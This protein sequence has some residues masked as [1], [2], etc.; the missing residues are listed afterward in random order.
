VKCSSVFFLTLVLCSVAPAHSQENRSLVLSQTISLPNVQGGFNHMSVDVEHMRLFVAAPTNNTLEIVDLKTG[1]PWRTLEGGKP[2]AVRYAPEFNQLYVPRGQS[3]DIYDGKTL[4]PIASIDLGSNLDELQYNASAKRLYV[5]CMAPDKTGIAVIAI[6]EGKLLGKIPLPA[7]LQGVAVEQKGSRIFANI[8]GV[9]QIALMDGE[10]GTLLN[11]WL[12]EDVEG[13][14]PLG[15]DEAHH[16]LFVGTRHPAQLLV[17]DTTTGKPTAKVDISSDADDLFYDPVNKRI[18][19]S[20]GEGFIDVIEQ[21]DADHYKLSTRIPTV[22]GA[23]TST[24]S[25]KLNAFYLGVPRR[26]G[27]PAEL[28]IFKVEK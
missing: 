7:K 5:A 10:Q 2:A 28:R 19:V 26:G 15:L 13:N 1:K 25:G 8:P 11:T 16:R 4:D 27:Q 3:L 21:R 9:K 12:L 18:Y 22:A 20:C 23:R 14:S 17:L 6:P 24:F